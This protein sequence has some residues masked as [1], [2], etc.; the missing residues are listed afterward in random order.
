MTETRKAWVR[1]PKTAIAEYA[2]ETRDTNLKELSQDPKLRI[3]LNLING[4]FYLVKQWND[5]DEYWFM[6]SMK[7][8][9]EFYA[10]QQHNV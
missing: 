3:Y 10:F 2:D 6:G 4:S 9:G 8:I 1:I 5:L 7:E